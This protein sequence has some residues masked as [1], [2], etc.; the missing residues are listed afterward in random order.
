MKLIKVSAAVLNQTPLDWEGNKA[1]IV[2]AIEAARRERVSLLCLPELC[3][4]GYGC[5]DAFLSPGLQA[6]ARQVLAEILPATRGMIVSLGLPLLYHHGLFNAACLAV[7]GRIAGFAAKRFL[8]GDGLHY[9]PRWFKPWPAGHRGEVEIGGVDYPLGDVYFDCGGLKIGFEICEDAWVANRPGGEL[10]LRG[11]D[12]I[13]NPSASHF[14]FGK[15][16][17]RHRFVLEGSRAFGVSYLYS[18][19]LGNEAGRAVYDGGALI[20]STGKLLAAGPRFSFAEYQLTSASI[21][22]DATRMVQSRTGSFRPSAEEDVGCVRAA[23]EFPPLEPEPESISVAAWERGPFVKEEEFAR[24]IS[25]ALFDYLRKSRS[26]GFVVSI[27][28]G[29]DSAAVA[30]LSALAVEFGAAELGVEGFQARLKYLMRVQGK[31]DAQAMIHALLCCVYQS[32]AHSSDVTRNAARG[33]ARGLGAEYLEWDVEQI[34]EA[35]ISTVSAAV[36]RELTWA[37]DDLA[38]QNIQARARSPGVWMLTNLRGALLLSTSN[39]SE[40]AVGYAT[41]DGDTSGG[42]SPIAGIDK[43]FLRR[44]LRWLEREGPAGLAPIPALAAVNCQEPTA[45]LRP[46]SACQ[47]DEQDLMPYEL[48]DEI[49]RAAIRDKY[50]PLETFLRMRSRF[51]QYDQPQLAMWVERFFL[52]WSRNQWKRERY[53]PSFHVDDENLDPKTWCRFPILSGGFE[54]ELAEL[55]N[56]LANLESRRREPPG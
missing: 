25:L 4:T 24:A 6:T 33:V 7:D 43:A 37:G 46:S 53:A 1:R 36:G 31:T 18:N 44:W 52:L 50:T 9:E 55:R 38:L 34:V 30:C 15:A 5:E 12:V 54:R 17:V 48:L 29:A 2:A 13:L 39:R 8:A 47:T 51:T 3:I 19:L 45:E 49:E 32:T 10:A 41:M 21:D 11:V 22:V 23:F 16:E 26:H 14:A 28:G 20:A 40:A 27:S 42:L 35:Y 56:Y